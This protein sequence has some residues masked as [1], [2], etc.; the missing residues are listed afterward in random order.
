[1]NKKDAEWLS[2]HKGD[3]PMWLFLFVVYYFPALYMAAFTDT[4]LGIV[5]F[6]GVSGIMSLWVMTWPSKA[7]KIMKEKSWK[8]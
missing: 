4:P 5:L 2:K 6:C 3:W 7:E 8:N 1:M